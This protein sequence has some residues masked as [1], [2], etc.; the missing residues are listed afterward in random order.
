MAAVIAEATAEANQDQFFGI[1]FEQLQDVEDAYED[2]EPDIVCS[3]H[4]YD[5]DKD[6]LCSAHIIDTG[7]TDNIHP[8]DVKLSNYPNPYRDFELIMNHTGQR[9]NNKTDVYTVNSFRLVLLLSN[10]IDC[11]YG[12]L[13][14]REGN[15][16]RLNHGQTLDILS[17]V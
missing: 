4:V 11:L 1:S 3:A 7:A 8:S 13:G 14:G 16:S 2:N 12:G 10:I 5:I 9:I 6:I 15:V 17:R